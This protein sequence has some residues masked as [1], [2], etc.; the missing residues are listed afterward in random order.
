[1]SGFIFDNAWMIPALPLISILLICLLTIGSKT[2]AAGIIGCAAIGTA[3][4]LTCWLGVSYISS[5]DE[6]ASAVT[7]SIEWLR[8]QDHLVVSLGTLIDPISILLLFV[9]TSVSLLV[10]LY[11]IG[12]MAG[13]EGFS[14]YFAYLS[15]FTFSMLGLVLAPN[16]VQMF[17]FWELVGVSS[18]LL[19]G[20]Y[21]TLP[22]AIAASK[23]AFIVTRFA[24]R[25]STRLNSSH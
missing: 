13:D 7:W 14:R 16:L 24:D 19:I 22:E 25:K 11:S 5:A 1:M 15:L 21:Y 4:L 12:Y 2:R 8:Y 17:V 6:G 10:H 23:K 3:F 20:F 18:F 9:V